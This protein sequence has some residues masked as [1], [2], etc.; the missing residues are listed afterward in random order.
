[1]T[2]IKEPCMF[3]S[4]HPKVPG[5]NALP[6]NGNADNYWYVRMPTNPPLVNCKVK[7]QLMLCEE[8]DTTLELFFPHNR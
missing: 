8:E 5:G 4:I 7:M 6:T 1:M 3:E 2:H